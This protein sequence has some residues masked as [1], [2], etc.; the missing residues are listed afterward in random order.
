MFTDISYYTFLS[1]AKCAHNIGGTNES[2]FSNLFL[3][4]HTDVEMKEERC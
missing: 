1:K 3:N 4:Y 2:R